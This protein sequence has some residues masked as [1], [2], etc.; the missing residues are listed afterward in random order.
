MI[1]RGEL[2][3]SEMVEDGEDDWEVLVDVDGDF[4]LSKSNP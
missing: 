3:D 1:A 2:L 4:T